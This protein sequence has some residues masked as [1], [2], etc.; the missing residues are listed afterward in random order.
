[1]TINFKD[2][3]LN[4][5]YL[6]YQCERDMN[7]RYLTRNDE[8]YTAPW[9]DLSASLDKAFRHKL[10]D[11]NSIKESKDLKIINNKNITLSDFEHII[12]TYSNLSLEKI[13]SSSYGLINIP[14]Y[15]IDEASLTFDI[16]G[17]V[18]YYKHY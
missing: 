15:K 2:E 13:L 18:F 17:F 11:K 1:M 9:V 4:N 5:F 14:D 16:D 12:T 6:K 7:T 8:C 3:D 10:I